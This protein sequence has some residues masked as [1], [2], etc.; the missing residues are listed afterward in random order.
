MFYNIVIFFATYKGRLQEC[1]GSLR[2]GLFPVFVVI[3]ENLF[4][5]VELE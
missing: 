1:P 2:T 4:N 5:H 3:D